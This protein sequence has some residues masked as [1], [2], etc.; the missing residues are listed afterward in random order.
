MFHGPRCIYNIIIVC[1]L[2]P[3]KFKQVSRLIKQVSRFRAKATRRPRGG[4]AGLQC[5]ANQLLIKSGHIA[6]AAPKARFGPQTLSRPHLFIHYYVSPV[7]ILIYNIHVIYIYIYTCVYHCII[8]RLH[9]FSPTPH[10]SPLYNTHVIY[11]YMC[12]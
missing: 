4:G 9:F 5:Q 10:P 8:T 3:T 7:Y 6:L 12:I 2:P 1:P 11:V